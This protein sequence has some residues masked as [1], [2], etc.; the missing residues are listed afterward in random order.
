MTSIFISDMHDRV[1][2]SDV[3]ELYISDAEHD[4]VTTELTK[5]ED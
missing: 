2:P 3:Y 4:M 5:A 1:A